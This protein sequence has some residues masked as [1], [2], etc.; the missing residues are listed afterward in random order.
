MGVFQKLFDMFVRE[1]HKLDQ[2]AFLGKVKT[3]EQA[4]LGENLFDEH[5]KEEQH[6]VEEVKKQLENKEE[7]LQEIMPEVPLP[8]LRDINRPKEP[9][10]KHKPAVTLYRQLK[11][12]IQELVSI[13]VT[14]SNLL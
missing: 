6:R 3:T 8:Y 13:K 10:K 7:E 9:S 5:I 1:V 11:E 14:N 2:S 4:D 12:Q